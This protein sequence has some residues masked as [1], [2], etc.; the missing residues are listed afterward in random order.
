MDPIEKSGKSNC[1][2]YILS[3][4]RGLICTDGRS[5]LVVVGGTQDW[6]MLK[7]SPLK[8][9]TNRIWNAGKQHYPKSYYPAQL[10][11]LMSLR[12]Q[13]NASAASVAVSTTD[14]T[15]QQTTDNR[16]WQFNR[17]TD[18]TVQ[19]QQAASLR[20]WRFPRCSSSRQKLWLHLSQICVT[21][22]TNEKPWLFGFFTNM[23]SHTFLFN[24]PGY[25]GC[26]WTQQKILF[27]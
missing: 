17:H 3:K 20:R 26:G 6:F 23:K 11:T 7:E 25:K 13:T 9:H 5:V 1:S 16:H 18:T 24:H 14:T 8:I 12:D 2:E 10:T 27:V 19:Q 22:S 21:R 4:G 15:V